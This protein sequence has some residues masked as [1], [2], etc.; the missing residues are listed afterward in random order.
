M[1]YEVVFYDYSDDEIVV[2]QKFDTESDAEKWA[3]GLKYDY[4][5]IAIDQYGNDYWKTFYRYYNP[6]DNESYFNYSVRGCITC[7]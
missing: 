5:D 2:N 6:E 7:H 3:D 1:K 4:E